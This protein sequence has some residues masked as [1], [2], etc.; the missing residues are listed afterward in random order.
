[1]RYVQWPL[2]RACPR[3]AAPRVL[4]LSGPA[5]SVAGTQR[6]LP[7]VAAACALNLIPLPDGV[8]LQGYPHENGRRKDGG[9]GWTPLPLFDTAAGG[10]ARQ[11]DCYWCAG[12]GGS[13]ALRICTAAA[14]RLRF[15]ASC[16]PACACTPAGTRTSNTCISSLPSCPPTI[17]P[18]GAATTPPPGKGPVTPASHPLSSLFPRRRS[19]YY[20]T[21]RR[22]P[23]NITPAPWASVSHR[24]SAAEPALA[25]S[26]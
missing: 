1:M 5:W 4:G 18:A 17:C 26:R 16:L 15:P 9:Q 24:D 25:A 13:K 3:A 8:L 19:D 14:C 10:M 21:N 23:S 2:V 7:A 22:D 12:G 20:A 6:L 11:R